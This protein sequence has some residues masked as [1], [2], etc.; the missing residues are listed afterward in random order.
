MVIFLL[1]VH[2]QGSFHQ[3]HLMF[4]MSMTINTV[5]MICVLDVL[6]QWPE[7]VGLFMEQRDL[8]EH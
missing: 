2:Q 3:G 1:F 7:C 8:F 5:I 4:D 6:F